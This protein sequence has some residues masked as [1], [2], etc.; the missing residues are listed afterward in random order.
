M[1]V[2]EEVDDLAIEIASQALLDGNLVAFPTETVYGLGADAVN[3]SAVNR[4]YESKG[5]PKDHPVIIHISSIEMLSKWAVDIPKSARILANQ[6]WPGPLTIIL[7]K[8]ELA[9][10]LITGGQKTVAIRIPN[11][12][13]ALELLKRFEEKGG[14]GVVA[15]SANRFGAVSPTRAKHVLNELD[16]YLVESDVLLDGGNCK[17]GIESTIIFINDNDFKILRPGFISAKKIIQTLQMSNIWI[18][19]SDKHHQ[20]SVSG[21]LPNHY[22]PKAK[23]E[24][25]AIA[26]PGDGFI[27]LKNIQTPNLAIRLG[28]PK[29]DL[30]FAHSLYSNLREA[31]QLNLD[32][33][34]VNYQSFSPLGIAILDR[35]VR[36]ASR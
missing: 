19:E 22:K 8:S 21:N 20:L 5:R 1:K 25:N 35:L 14:F 29:D 17:I 18:S 6:F 28:E 12:P 7:K 31:D 13:I 9:S 15:P 26:H 4:M 23:V 36:A 27:A 33:V 3:T 34:V 16:S 24:I 30:E 10:D 32:R 2:F 11:H